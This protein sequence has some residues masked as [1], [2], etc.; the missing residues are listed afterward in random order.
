MPLLFAFTFD[1]INAQEGIWQPILLDVP[2]F[3]GQQ[4]QSSTTQLHR[5]QA[6]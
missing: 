5:S 6:G 1:L 2:F 4:Q 3:T